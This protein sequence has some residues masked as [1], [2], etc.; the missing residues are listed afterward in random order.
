M[1]DRPDILLIMTDQQRADTLGCLGSVHVQTP[2][3]DRLAARGLLFRNAF[4]PIP[5]CSPARASLWTGRYPHQHGVQDNVYRAEDALSVGGHRSVLADLQTAGYRTAYVGKWHLGERPP[6]EIDVWQGYNSNTSHWLDGGYRSFIETDAAI[7]L[8]EGHDRRQPLCLVVSYYPPHPPYD[9]PPEYAAAHAG[10]PS[11]GYF[12]AVR[13]IDDCVGRLLD[14]LDRSGLAETAAL[15]FCSDH[16]Q[17]MAASS[18]RN[19]KRNLFD[20]TIRIPMILVPPGGCAGGGRVSNRLVG[21]MDVAPTLRALAALRQTAESDA[22]RNLLPLL[23][24]GSPWRH[25]L[26]FQNR[27]R[28]DQSPDGAVRVDRAVRTAEAKLILRFG[29][30]PALYDLRADPD[31]KDDLMRVKPPLVALRRLAKAM[32][33]LGTEA[34]DELAVGAAE[35]ILAATTGVRQE[36]VGR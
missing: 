17:K 7:A 36:S 22:S 35:Q 13:A 28:A 9:P 3:L 2:H 31:E 4:T 29:R 27:T 33:R 15:L 14:A 11:P 16:G 21:L 34:G 30:P 32:R 23:N 24:D 10:S 5:I 19:V 12:G 6:P 8:L 18:G 1:P 26:L 25:A 20:E